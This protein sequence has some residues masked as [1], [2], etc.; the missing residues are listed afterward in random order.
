[1]NALTC[2]RLI[3]DL[4]YAMDQGRIPRRPLSSLSSA[5]VPAYLRWTL[6]QVQGCLQEFGMKLHPRHGKL[7]GS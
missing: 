3:D 5:E 2:L 1:M 6:Q 4:L 7:P